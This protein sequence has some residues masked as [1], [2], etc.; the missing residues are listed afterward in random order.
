[1]LALWSN[2]QPRRARLRRAEFSSFCPEKKLLTS[3]SLNDI[4][5]KKVEKLYLLEDEIMKGDRRDE[6]IQVQRV[7]LHLR[8]R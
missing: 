7:Q 1:M 3:I 2:I 8:G 6:E 5:D 4:L